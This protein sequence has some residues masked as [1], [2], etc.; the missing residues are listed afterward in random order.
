LGPSF[1]ES[2]P[3]LSSK[4]YAAD[5]WADAVMRVVSGPNDPRNLS[6]WGR[7]AGAARGTLR[8]WCRAAHVGARASLDF[9]RVLRAI[10]LSQGG[11][12][13]WH[14]LLDVVDGRT[15]DRLLTRGG[16]GDLK[17]RT[18]CPAPAAFIGAQRFIVNEVAVASVAA[19]LAPPAPP[20]PQS[21]RRVL[22]KQHVG[23]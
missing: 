20:L 16:V 21:A 2:E 8:G 10:V 22:E 5:R 17:W 12:L 1:K 18:G 9:A 13:D 19:R 15:L 3:P 23:V 6:Q 7:I 14:N 11:R 4:T